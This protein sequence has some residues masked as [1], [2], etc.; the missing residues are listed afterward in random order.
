MKKISYAIY[1]LLLAVIL[2]TLNATP[3]KSEKAVTTWA[4]IKDGGTSYAAPPAGP[5]DK[6][7]F[8]HY[9]RGRAGRPD[10][11]DKPGKPPK[12]TKNT[13]GTDQYEKYKFTGIQWFNL[14]VYWCYDPTDEPVDL[15]DAIKDSFKTWTDAEPNNWTTEYI[16]TVPGTPVGGSDFINT[17]CWRDLSIDYPGAIAMTMI[18]YVPIS[19][20]VGIA[21]EIDTYMGTNWPWA[22]KPAEVLGDQMDVQN[23]ATHEIGHWLVLDDLYD[24]C[25]SEL[26]MWG[27]STWE[28]TNKTTLGAGDKLGIQYVY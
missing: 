7:V 15:L 3:A 16:T 11:P 26:T 19:R 25:S 22:I 2:L 17:F 1:F 28:E 8:V 13:C 5:R 12:P 20:R 24:E 14:P 27:F 23:T 18:W 6:L 4:A 9:P 10:K 21:V